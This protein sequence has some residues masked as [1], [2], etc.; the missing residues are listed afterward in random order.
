MPSHREG[1]PLLP[2]KVFP[3]AGGRLASVQPAEGHV[4]KKGLPEAGLWS[5]GRG[6]PLSRAF[7]V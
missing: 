5:E 7:L 4:D 1:L 6:G 2:Y 3:S